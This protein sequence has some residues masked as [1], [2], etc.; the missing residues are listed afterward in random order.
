MQQYKAE[1]LIKNTKIKIC[2]T[3]VFVIILFFL[4]LICS[5]N[6]IVTNKVVTGQTA[7]DQAVKVNGKQHVSLFPPLMESI[8]FKKDIYFCDIKIPVGDQDVKERLE[9]ELLL[10]L[11]SRPQ[12]ILWIKRSAKF[13]PIIEKILRENGLP[14]DLKYIPIIESALKPHSASSKGA[15]GYWQFIRSTGKSYGLRIDSQVD[16]RRNI[17][18]STQAA[19]DYLKVLYKKFDSYLLAASAY[20]MGEYGLQKAINLQNNNTDFFSLYLPLE[21]Q[22]YAFKIICAKLILENQKSYGFNLAKSD[23]YPAFSYDK[24]NFKSHL[25]IPV[26]LVAKAAGVPFKKIKDYNPELR[27][28]YLDKGKIS[29]LIPKGKAKGFKKEFA[30]QYK[31]WNKKHKSRFHQVKA[32]DSLIGIARKYKVSLTSL[33]RLNKLSSKGVIHPGDRLIVE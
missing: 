7:G 33:L 17:F 19:C 5:A 2:V 23:L 27:G 11:W 18:K 25:Q 4:P 24:V 22:R 31:A 28:Y 32:G 12:V 20:N 8:Q 15:V 16:E 29:I 21:T 6:Q 30:A 26:A 13:F 10:A 9:K 1:K 14:T 3:L